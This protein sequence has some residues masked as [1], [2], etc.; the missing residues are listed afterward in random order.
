MESLFGKLSYMVVYSY[1]AIGDVNNGFTLL[2]R[3]KRSQKYFQNSLALLEQ[4]IGYASIEEVQVI[5]FYNSW[6][7]GYDT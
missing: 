5:L 1:M 3:L 2:T 6:F 4:S 7:E